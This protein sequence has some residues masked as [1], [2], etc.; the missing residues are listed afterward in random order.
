MW[1]V[2]SG[3]GGCS[4]PFTIIRYR[5]SL[6]GL[7]WSRYYDAYGGQPGYRIWHASVTTLPIYYADSFGLPLS[8]SPP[9]ISV[10]G[11]EN[12]RK[13]RVLT[14]ASPVAHDSLFIMMASAYT[15]GCGRDSLFLLYSTNG[16]TWTSFTEP[17]LTPKEG[18]WDDVGIYESTSVYDAST[19]LFKVWYSADGTGDT[20]RLGFTEEDFQTVLDGLKADTKE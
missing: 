14:L 18:S 9:E 4:A 3:S 17:L 20:W 12:P 10:P 6:D 7:Q 2:K 11:H 16:A 5:T 1:F 19:G 13:G 15:E 8:K